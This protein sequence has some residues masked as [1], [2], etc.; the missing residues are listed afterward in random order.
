MNFEDFSSEQRIK[1]NV[2]ELNQILQCLRESQYMYLIN[3][4]LIKIDMF[5][6]N[7]KESYV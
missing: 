2:V 6:I 1:K 7:L 5:K 4:Q 3:N